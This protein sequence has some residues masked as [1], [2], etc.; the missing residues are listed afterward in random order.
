MSDVVISVQNLSKRY[1]IGAREEGYKTFGKL[2]LMA[3]RPH[4]EIS[5]G[6]ET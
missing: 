5:D 2:L 1:H 3:S 6:F 4:F